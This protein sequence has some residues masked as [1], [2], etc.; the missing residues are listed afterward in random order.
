M[1]RARNVL[2][3]AEKYRDE[4][5]EGLARLVRIRSLSGQEE[6]VIAERARQLT[7]AGCERARSIPWATS[8]AGWAPASAC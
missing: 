6:E 3:L 1:N 4:T 8:S 7:D 5:A 2:A